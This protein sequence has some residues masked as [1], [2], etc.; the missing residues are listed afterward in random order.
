MRGGAAQHS[1]HVGGERLPL[2]VPPLPRA[3]DRLPEPIAAVQARGRATDH[4]AW[5]EDACGFCL[6]HDPPQARR[7]RRLCVLQL[8]R[9]FRRAVRAA[10]ELGKRPQPAARA[11]RYP[12][13]GLDCARASSPKPPEP[14]PLSCDTHVRHSN[15]TLSPRC[16]H[17]AHSQDRACID[18]ADVN[19]SLMCLP[20]FLAGCQKL[21]VLVGPTFATRLWY[22]PPFLPL[23]DQPSG[24][25][26]LDDSTG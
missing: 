18:T 4:H 16:P 10:S 8:V 12:S 11:G 5:P 20:V 7:G 25:Q 6:L 2:G 1:R 26:P 24:V 19:T 22:T 3:A 23:A 9:Q 13:H 21:L 15:R 17:A 14:R